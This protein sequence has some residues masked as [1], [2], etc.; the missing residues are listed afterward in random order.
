MR[1]LDLPERYDLPRTL[2]NLRL[3]GGDPTVLMDARSGWFA[4]RTPDGPGT[5]QFQ[6]DGRTLTATGYGP[7][8]Q[9]LVD[10]ADEIAGLQ[11]RLDGFAEVA[12]HHPLVARLA[13][14]F[15]GVR[16]PATGRVFHHV[17]PAVIGQKVT[18]KEAMH[19]YLRVLRH[20]AEPAPG[21]NGRVML[22]PEPGAIAQTPYWTF[23][24]YGLEQRRTEAMR[25]AAAVAAALEAAG[26]SAQTTRRLMSIAGIGVWTAAEVVRASHGD[27]DAVSVGDYHIKN[28][29]SW[30][31]AGEPRGTDERMLE[32][33]EPFAGHRGRV[34]RLFEVAGIGAPKYGPRMPVRSFARF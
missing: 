3:L 26:D 23:H 6:R 4:T 20:F 34:C 25:R 12:R 5:L 32:L 14:Q 10:R 22:P 21:P 15:A 30:A 1:R 9:W 24:P 27:P 13:H 18:G 8:G 31:L 33:L 17:V 2:A 16:F 19:S 29:V 11:D 28:T 7:G